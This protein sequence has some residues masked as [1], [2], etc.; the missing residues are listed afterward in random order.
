MFDV[1]HDPEIDP[2]LQRNGAG[3]NASGARTEMAS[4]QNQIHVQTQSGRRMSDH[5]QEPPRKRARL[6]CNACKARKTK[7]VGFDSGSCEHCQSLGIPC[8]ADLRSRKRPFYRVSGEVY[9]YSIK[10]LRRFVPE[11]QLP[12]LTVENIQSLLHRLESTNHT[13]TSH[14]QV[15]RVGESV[16]ST[17]DDAAIADPDPGP[18]PAP[19]DNGDRD[20]SRGTNEVMEPDEH[21]LLQEEFGCMLLDSMGKYRYVGADS[22]IRWNHVVRMAR[23]TTRHP[24]KMIIPPLKTGLLPPT[25]PES[26]STTSPGIVR[27]PRRAEMYLPPRAACMAYASR[28]FDQVHCIYWFFSG[29]Q[30]Y[31]RLDKTLE[32]RGTTD[33]S[34]WLCALYSIFAMGSMRPEGETGGLPPDEKTSLDYLS[35]ARELSTGAADEADMDSIKAFGL[36]SLATHATCYSVTA[37][38]HL[39][40]A[41]RI[42]FSL[43]LHRDVTPGLGRPNPSLEREWSRRLWWTIFTLDH[44][45]ASRFGYPCSISHDAS[46]VV[47]R[48]PPAA[49]HILDPG[50]HTPLGYQA[51]AVSLVK[52]RKRISHECFLVPAAQAGGRLPIRRVTGCLSALRAFADEIP[53]H[54][55]A[56]ASLHPQHRRAVA[57][58]HLRYFITVISLTRPFLLF[59]ITTTTKEIHPE[60]MR[61]YNQLSG[62]CIDAA[63][64][65]IPILRKMRGDKTLSSLTLLDCH[66]IG[67]VMWILILA[68]QK[69]EGD[70]KADERRE[71]LR[72]CLDTLRGMERVG[73]CAKV[74]PEFEARVMESGV[75][76]GGEKSQQGGDGDGGQQQQQGELVG[77]NHSGMV[78]SGAVSGVG[79]VQDVGEVGR[80]GTGLTPQVSGSLWDYPGSNL[81]A[82]Q[83][84]V[85]ETLDF[86]SGARLGR[87][88]MDMFMDASF[89]GSQFLFDNLDGIHPP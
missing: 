35:M 68:L 69:C 59:T 24:S 86:S 50:P 85:F 8:E 75:L 60:K 22:S 47:L 20:R 26:P 51:L 1:D 87:M 9:E 16:V 19:D 53:T 76:F 25:T 4:A 29:E 33:S 88:D 73:W 2:D 36:L 48:T 83:F 74:T 44:E 79:G 11:D 32:D 89:S 57:L 70:K 49:E 39:G 80:T 6:S 31:T 84:D 72:L 28:F 21:P 67:E 61:L 42:G 13:T 52:L 56:D 14:E 65:A 62:T 18:G 41:V 12:E 38:L 64:A 7:C 43:G 10:L 27:Q 58:L 5:D 3:G 37:Y 15:P 66:C 55:R 45:M 77:I 71:M 30:F 34:S 82:M 40:T 63:E 46:P 17:G 54:L 23:E 81:D 78:L